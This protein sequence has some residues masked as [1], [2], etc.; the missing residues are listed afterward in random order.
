MILAD[1]HCHLDFDELAPDFDTVM[2]RARAVGIRRFVTIGVRVR[3]HARVLAKAEAH[4]DVFC[5]VGTHPHYADEET[6]I[7][8][9][10]LI[11]HAHHPK[12]V[13]I[14]EVGLDTF[15]ANAPWDAQMRNLRAH[16]V[17]ARET[18][19][20][21]VI[22]S[23]RQ[24]EAM[25]QVLREESASGAFPIV[26][27]C[28]SGGPALARTC[29]DLGAYLSFSGMLTFPERDY[30]REIARDLPAD[31]ILV[32]TDAPSLAPVPYLDQRNEPAYLTHVV[33]C[34]ARLRGTSAE[35]IAE[36][37]T[38]NF[39]AAFEKIPPLEQLS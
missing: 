6:D 15:L 30:L 12:V 36:Q 31:R 17:A 5:T 3:Q 32:E 11:A 16:I 35:T 28:F 19:L 26:M 27:H 4:D 14:G 20:P 33:A 10:D 21:L 25:A 8:A 13:G 37:T 39:F 2:A 24:D 38:R 1:S 22:H 29:L 18:R 9:D 23:V 34:L 7:S